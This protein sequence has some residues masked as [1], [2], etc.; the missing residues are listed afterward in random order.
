MRLHVDLDLDGCDT[1]GIDD[2]T[3][4]SVPAGRHQPTF[5]ALPFR[6]SRARSLAEAGGII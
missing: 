6:G 5:C 3:C 4:P 1:A 2:L